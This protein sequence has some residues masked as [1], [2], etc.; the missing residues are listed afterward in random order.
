MET[1]LW[2]FVE[3][4]TVSFATWDWLII[5]HEL[6]IQ[7]GEAYDNWNVANFVS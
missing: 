1:L 2:Y 3:G 7:E 6:D 4:R 5:D